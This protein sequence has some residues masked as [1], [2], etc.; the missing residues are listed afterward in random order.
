[1]ASLLAVKS[2]AT[3]TAKLLGRE[4]HPGRAGKVSTFVQWSGVGMYLISHL[5]KSFEANQTS[6]NTNR[7]ARIVNRSGIALV[8]IS[9]AGYVIDASTPKRA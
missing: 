3:C 2:I 9:A 6:Q 8:I 1:M 7:A 4:T 5:A